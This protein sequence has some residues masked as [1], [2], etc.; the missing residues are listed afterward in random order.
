M[1]SIKE[2]LNKQLDRL[3]AVTINLYADLNEQTGVKRF[4]IDSLTRLILDNNISPANTIGIINILKD[5][6]DINIYII[7][8]DVT[9]SSSTIA[10][11]CNVKN[12]LLLNNENCI[13]LLCS[14]H[15]TNPKQLYYQIIGNYEG[16]S[17]FSANQIAFLN[18]F[19][20]PGI[21]RLPVLF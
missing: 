13:F 4:T 12:N 9:S 15:P 2:T 10:I 5:V 17:M 16:I 6:L 11:E 8:Y 21:N 7:Y 14:D 1:E 20:W 18:S 3:N 19:H